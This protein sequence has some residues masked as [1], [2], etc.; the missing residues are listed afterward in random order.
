MSLSEAG[1]F[2]CNNIWKRPCQYVAL[3][4]YFT[5]MSYEFRLV[6]IS[7]LSCNIHS[8]KMFSLLLQKIRSDQYTSLW[9]KNYKCFQFELTRMIKSTFNG[10][11]I[12]SS[13]IENYY[14]LTA[15]GF[16]SII[17]LSTMFQSALARSLSNLSA[18]AVDLVSSWKC[19]N[20]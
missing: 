7:T 20:V 18:M 19:W 3:S 11:H 16:W 8:I 14:V 5:C 6:E 13:G 9:F 17:A 4:F 15:Y 10:I 1:I 12:Y 2:L